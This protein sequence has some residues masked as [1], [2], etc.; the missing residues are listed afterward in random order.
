MSYQGP[1]KFNSTPRK[2]FDKYIDRMAVRRI[3]DL[4]NHRADLQS[5]FRK[6]ND[7]Q[8]HILDLEDHVRSHC[9][10]VNSTSYITARKDGNEELE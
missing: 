7:M 10:T 3:R 8:Q 9:D 1:N 5:V 6:I 2:V 4:E